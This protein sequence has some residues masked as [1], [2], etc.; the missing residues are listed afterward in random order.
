MV[1]N[2]FKNNKTITINDTLAEEYK[3]YFKEIDKKEIE[4]LVYICNID[5]S[6]KTD[7]EL[8]KEVC[9][10]LKENLIM[11]KDGINNIL[12]GNISDDVLV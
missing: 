3:K 10:Y 2:I 11:I 7:E 9:K 8:S 4:N 12:E 5:Y 1:V 6:N